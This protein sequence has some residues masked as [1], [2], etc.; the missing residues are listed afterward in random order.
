MAAPVEESRSSPASSSAAKPEVQTLQNTLDNQQHTSNSTIPAQSDEPL[1]PLP[2]PI[3][4][5]KVNSRRAG[6]GESL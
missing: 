6:A 2:T 5:T 4:K 3:V 1:T